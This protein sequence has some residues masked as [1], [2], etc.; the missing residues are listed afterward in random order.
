MVISDGR[1]MSKHLGNVVDPDALVE[2]Y[3]ADTVR[4]AV[5]Y[6]ARPQ[7]TL[8]WNDS[9]VLRA[10][11]FLT[12]VWDF[13]QSRLARAQEPADTEGA[14]AADGA[15]ATANGDGDAIR[16]TT[17]HL[18][19]KL[20]QWCEKG[21]EKITEDMEGLEMHSAVRN[22]MRLFDRIKDYEKRVLA[23]Q[24]ALGR[25]DSDALLQALSLLAQLLGPF[26]PHIAEELWVALGNDES[27]VQTP[28]PGVSFQEVAA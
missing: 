16:D 9:S 23:R 22:V 28:W 6:A 15:L 14:A 24:E 8:N 21:V 17:E 20:S 19:L 1:K 18:R 7:K 5:L 26:A 10:H 25:A 11:R 2:R 27:A 13:S 12:Q 4:L 3:G